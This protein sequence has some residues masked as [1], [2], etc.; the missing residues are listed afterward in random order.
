MCIR[1]LSTRSFGQYAE[2]VS[3]TAAEAAGVSLSRGC[4][5]CLCQSEPL[6]M[7]LLLTA[8][9]VS[10]MHSRITSSHIVNAPFCAIQDSPNP[11]GILSSKASGEPSLMMSMGVLSALQQAAA[12]ARR[13]LAELQRRPEALSLGNIMGASRGAGIF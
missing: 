13:D 7:V 5:T 11:R 9:N 8:A 1:L 12:A 2:P 10:L 6:Q 4:V 3:L